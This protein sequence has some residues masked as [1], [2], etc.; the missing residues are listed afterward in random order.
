MNKKTNT[1][2]F[3]L[4]ATVFNLLT[5]FLLLTLGII[6]TSLILQGRDPG[7]VGSLL[8]F[9]VFLLAVGGSFFIYHRV[10][11]FI[12]KKIDIERYF[13]PLIKPRRR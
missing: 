9:L 8:L 7:G 6:L 3:I 5:V 13:D 2:L 12:S 11:K 10:V 1:F 4:G